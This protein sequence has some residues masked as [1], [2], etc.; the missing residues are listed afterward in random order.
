MIFGGLN[1][2]FKTNLR[3]F[4]ISKSINSINA[5]N[6]KGKFKTANGLRGWLGVTI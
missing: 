4:Q 2:H 6:L 1:R 5:K 3:N